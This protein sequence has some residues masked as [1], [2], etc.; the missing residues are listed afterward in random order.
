MED[1][2]VMVIIFRQ[3]SVALSSLGKSVPFSILP[4]SWVFMDLIFSSG[5]SLFMV[6]HRS[7]SLFMVVCPLHVYS[8]HPP[9]VLLGVI[10]PEV[11]G[12]EQKAEATVA[13]M[14]D[15]LSSN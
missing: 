1:L 5:S 4:S 9:L 2:L 7:S 10:I 3:S 8:M 12:K 6:A 14:S 15:L 13:L 11:G